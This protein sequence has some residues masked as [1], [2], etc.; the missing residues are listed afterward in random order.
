MSLAAL[1]SS[2][3][4]LGHK[5]PSDIPAIFAVISFVMGGSSMHQQLVSPWATPQVKVVPHFGQVCD[6]LIVLKQSK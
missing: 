6:V 4:Q 1:A 2:L 3:R 5:Q